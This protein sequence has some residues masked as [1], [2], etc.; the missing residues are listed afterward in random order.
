MNKPY[1]IWAADSAMFR[2]EEYTNKWSY[3]FGV[4]L[5]GIEAVYLKTGD[6]TY[7]A[8]I[9]RTMDGFIQKDGSIPLYQNVNN[10]DHINLGKNILFL[11]EHFQ[12]IYEDAAD[13][14]TTAAQDA[15]ARSVRYKKAA[16]L[17]RE[18]LKHHPRTS[19]GVFW[20]KQIYPYQ[21][22]LDG[23]YMASPF[24]A[25]YLRD[26][27]HHQDYSDVVKQVL[28]SFKHLYNP[29]TG[30]M[31]HAIDESRESFW[32]DKV[33]GHSANY[34][35]RSIGWYAMACVD[36]LDFLPKDHADRAQ[37]IHVL[38]TVID[39]MLPYR[40]TVSNV[41]Y[42]VVNMQQT[43]G[44][45]K[46]ASGSSMMVY[47]MAKGVVMGYLSRKKYEPIIEACYQG[48][49]DEF[50]TITARDL[51][52]VNKICQSAGLGPEKDRNRDGSFAYYISEPIICNAPFGIGSFILASVYVEMLYSVQ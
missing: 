20:H 31:H 12:N 14:N 35:A 15:T 13:K 24:Y 9:M 37:I 52:N 18:Q 1:S 41:W 45:Y 5:K 30:L 16:T 49:L 48:L 29:E 50:V 4:L 28:L 34:W 51:L 46:E 17:L 23:I 36:L 2:R 22:W 26:I 25:Q 3:D 11:Y 47:A 32:C 7:L 19:D 40:D 38:K 27:E 42:Q 8:Y 33:S 44:N 6:E 39:G 10:I 21:I 43:K